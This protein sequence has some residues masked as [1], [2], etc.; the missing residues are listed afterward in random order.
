M[1]NHVRKQ[2]RDAVVTAVT[3][4]ATTGARV[5]VDREHPLDPDTEVPALL[6]STPSESAVPED[7]HGGIARTVTVIV[8]AV[9]KATGAVQD[10]AD[11]VAKEV[12]AELTDPVALVVGGK[13]CDVLYTG[14]V[15]S[16]DAS[17]DRLTV[18]LEMTF[19]VEVFTA[20]GIPDVLQ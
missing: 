20:A 18:E 7:I 19:D 6:V 4:L 5:F 13:R 1:A 16:K 14:A 11:Q 3:G 9:V 8:T 17:A 10:T 15:L 2:L 12:E